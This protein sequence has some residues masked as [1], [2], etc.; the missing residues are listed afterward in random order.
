MTCDECEALA[1]VECIGRDSLGSIWKCP[2][3]GALYAECYFYRYIGEEEIVW[4]CV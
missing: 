2:V 1:S 3:C 4:W